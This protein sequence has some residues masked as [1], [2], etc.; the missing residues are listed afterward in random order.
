MFG[1][2]ATTWSCSYSS[3]ITNLAKFPSSTTLIRIRSLLQYMNV[4]A[5][6]SWLDVSMTAVALPVAI[7]RDPCCGAVNCIDK[8]TNAEGDC[9]GDQEEEEESVSA[10]F[11]ALSINARRSSVRSAT[12][13]G[14]LKAFRI[15]PSTFRGPRSNLSYM[16]RVRG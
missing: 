14:F 12:I 16:T 13:G 15:S 7:E 4:Y 1:I 6:A 2:A 11:L 9:S 3:L 10:S 8:V 5:S